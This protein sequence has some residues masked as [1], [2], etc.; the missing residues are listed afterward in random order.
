MQH[1]GEFEDR[2]RTELS[3]AA[4]AEGIYFLDFSPSN[5]ETNQQVAARV[6][7]FFDKLIRYI[8]YKAIRMFIHGWTPIATTKTIF[9]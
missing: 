6:R 3:I 2:P 7:E 9:S 8:H 4:E 1:Y 5:G